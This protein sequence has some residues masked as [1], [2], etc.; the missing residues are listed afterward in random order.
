M[1]N[2]YGSRLERIL[3]DSRPIPIIRDGRVTAGIRNVDC[4]RPSLLHRGYIPRA[5]RRKEKRKKYREMVSNDRAD[6]INQSEVTLTKSRTVDNSISKNR[7]RT[8]PP[9][10]FHFFRLTFDKCS[11]LRNRRGKNPRIAVQ[12]RLCFLNRPSKKPSR[13]DRGID[14]SSAFV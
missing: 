6:N 10:L 14:G 8:G 1:R 7:A 11:I 3:F 12:F 5:K 2:G 9:P 4:Y 13:R